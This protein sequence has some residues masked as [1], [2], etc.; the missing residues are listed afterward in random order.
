M[1]LLRHDASFKIL[2][3]TPSNAA[4]DLLV[5]RLAAAG[6][7]VD[8]LHRLNA[9]SRDIASIPEPVRAFSV[10]PERLNLLA[11]RVVISTCS[12]AGLLQNHHIPTRHFSH[13]VIDEAA[14]A[15]EPLT[16]IPIAAF[17]H[18]HTNVILAGDPH[19][20]GPVIKS[21]PASQAGLG[22]CYLE[23]LMLISEVYGL[24]TQAGNT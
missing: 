8:Q 15:E 22:K 6:L 2:V 3:C 19:Q 4:S 24:S 14:Q 11:F 10:I 21:N 1:Q 20:L 9:R 5:E 18:K 17:C 7:T 13:I 12:S 23:R 16:L